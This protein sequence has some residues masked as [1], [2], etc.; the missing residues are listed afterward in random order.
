MK[1][2]KGY[3]R[4]RRF[5]S[6]R[7]AWIATLGRFHNPTLEGLYLVSINWRGLAHRWRDLFHPS[8]V[9]K[10]MGWDV[11]K[12]VSNALSYR[13]D[14]IDFHPMF[15]VPNFPESEDYD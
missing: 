5:F 13:F 3:W 12:H 9:V 15:Y 10:R 11:Q 1:H 6:Y 14:K 7:A 8:A 4:D 2:Y